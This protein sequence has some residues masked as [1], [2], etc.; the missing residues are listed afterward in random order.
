MSIED[1]RQYIQ[2][3][4]QL[5][6][7]IKTLVQ[8]TIDDIVFEEQRAESERYLIGGV[9]LHRGWETEKQE[10]DFILQTLWAIDFGR[11][12]EDN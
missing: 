4:E 7:E 2:E 9:D 6:E 1:R 12:Y 11:K 8:L 10:L 5:L 3:C